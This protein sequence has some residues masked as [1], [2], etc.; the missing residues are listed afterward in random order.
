MQSSQ[1]NWKIVDRDVKHQHKQAN[2]IVDF[3]QVTSFV[4]KKLGAVSK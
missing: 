3:V 1:H 4:T 2:V